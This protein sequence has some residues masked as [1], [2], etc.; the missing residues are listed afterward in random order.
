[1]K[2]EKKINDNKNLNT[3]DEERKRRENAVSSDA[4]AQMRRTLLNALVEGSFSVE[5]IGQTAD[6]REREVGFSSKQNTKHKLLSETEERTNELQLTIKF[7]L[8]APSWWQTGTHKKT[9]E[10]GR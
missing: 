1:M 7:T 9:V 5:L 6:R 2:R 4:H 3:R 10:Q 8:V